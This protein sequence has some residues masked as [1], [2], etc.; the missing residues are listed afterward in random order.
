MTDDITA[1]VA[2]LREMLVDPDPLRTD[3]DWIGDV[4]DHIPWALDTIE[5]LHRQWQTHLEIQAGRP[6]ACCGTCSREIEEAQAAESAATTLYWQRGQTIQRLQNRL[7][8]AHR[9]WRR[10]RPWI[11]GLAKDHRALCEEKR[12]IQ[13]Q[14]QTLRDALMWEC[15]ARARA[16]ALARSHEARLEEQSALL[17]ALARRQA[18]HD[19]TCTHRFCRDEDCECRLAPNTPREVTPDA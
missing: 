5:R 17:D 8:R 12:A 3:R 15:D 13:E 1:R 18:V 11:N 16:F 6:S 7:R 2:E 19:I 10:N 4:F 14:V 9:Q